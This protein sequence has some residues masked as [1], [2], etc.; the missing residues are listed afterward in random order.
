LNLRLPKRAR[1][2][3]RFLIIT[4]FILLTLS[5]LVLFYIAQTANHQSGF[6]TNA[7]LKIICGLDLV[8]LLAGMT[9][10]FWGM[11]VWMHD[12]IFKN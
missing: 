7:G 12:K 3:S 4:G 8:A 11:S 6:V 1:R 9:I 2:R 10:L 5:F